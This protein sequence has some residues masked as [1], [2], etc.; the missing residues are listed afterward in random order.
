MKLRIELFFPPIKSLIWGVPG[1]VLA[2]FF[3][4]MSAVFLFRRVVME[5]IGMQRQ[6]WS[7]C[8][9]LT[10]INRLIDIR[11]RWQCHFAFEGR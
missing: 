8:N 2:E 9:F 6:P 3:A 10:K 1:Q 11:R 4:Q 5:Q 7:P